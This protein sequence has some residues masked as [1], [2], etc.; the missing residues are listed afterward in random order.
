MPQLE[1]FPGFPS[2]AAAVVVGC[3]DAHELLGLCILLGSLHKA[4]S[5]HVKQAPTAV[6]RCRCQEKVSSWGMSS[7]F[8]DTSS[9]GMSSQQKC[10]VFV[11]A[12]Y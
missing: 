12:F 6:K 7:V 4:R 8:N 5:M 10:C 3:S 1:R 11:L 9:L 2:V